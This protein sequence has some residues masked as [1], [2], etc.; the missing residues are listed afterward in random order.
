MKKSLLLL[1]CLV[2][3]GCANSDFPFCCEQTGDK[4]VPYTTTYAF[5]KKVEFTDIGGTLS[6]LRIISQADLANLFN[7]ANVSRVP[8][9]GV[10]SGN[11]LPI[12]GGDVSNMILEATDV[13]GDKIGDLFYNSLG[14]IPDFSSQSGTSANGGFSLLNAPS[15]EVY[16]RVI[17]GGRGKT[18]MLSIP[19]AV[20]LMNISAAAVVPPFIGMLG[21]IQEYW[22]GVAV[23][24][25]LLTPV[26]LKGLSVF[27]SSE[28]YRFPSL[29]SDSHFLIE[30]T[31]AGYLPTYQEVVTDLSARPDGAVD[32]T[33]PLQTLSQASLQ[34]IL[35]QTLF[36]WDPAN[37]QGGVLI[38][39][40]RDADE[41]DRPYS[42]LVLTDDQG[43][44]LNVD[45][46]TSPP[47]SRIYLKGSY[48]DPANRKIPTYFWYDQTGTQVSYIDSSSK[49]Q[50]YDC[51]QTL[52]KSCPPGSIGTPDGSFIVFNLPP[53]KVNLSATA[54]EESAQGLLYFTGEE[55]VEIFPQSA[56][57]KNVLMNQT[58]LGKNTFFQ[59]L[60]GNVMDS[61][62]KTPIGFAAIFAL[63][64]SFSLT[65]DLY[66]FFNTPLNSNILDRVSYTFK[67]S[68]PSYLDTYQ[69]IK[70]DAAFKS[71]TIYSDA[72]L[73]Q[74]LNAAGLST[75]YDSSKG[76][77]AGM[78]VDNGTG[79]GTDGIIL[80]ATDRFGNIVG[81]A[82][83][84][85]SSGLPT[86]NKA[87][88]KNGRYII[89]NL[90]EGPIQVR[91]VSP[92][93]SGNRWVHIYSRGVFLS[94]IHVNNGLPP[95]VQISGVTRDMDGIPAGGAA[96][97]VLGEK[98]RFQSAGDGSFSQSFSTL[99]QYRVKAR[100]P[101]LSLD[102]YSLFDTL[103]SDIG[104][105]T[106]WALTQA[107]ITSQVSNGPSPFTVDF[108]K[109]ILSGTVSSIGFSTP[110]PLSQFPFSPVTGISPQRIAAG[111]FDEDNEV[112]I[113]FVNGVDNKLT[114]LLG[115]G[116]GSFRESSGSPY[117][118]PQGTSLL[119]GQTCLTGANPV[120]VRS[121]DINGDGVLDLMVTNEGTDSM[122]VF[123]G[124]K[125]GNF[126]VASAPL[127]LP[128]G[129]AP[130]AVSVA[131]FNSDGKM[132]L[133]VLCSAASAYYFIPGNGDGTFSGSKYPYNTL[134]NLPV[135]ILSRDFNGDGNLD[136]AVVNSGSNRVSIFLGYGTG[137][138]VPAPNSPYP[139]GLFPVGIAAGDINGDG[140]VD[141]VIPNQGSGT[142]TVLLGKGGGLFSPAT[143][144]PLLLSGFPEFVALNDVN[145][146]GRA[147]LVVTTTTTMTDPGRI[148]T[149]SGLGDGTFSIETGYPVGESPSNLLIADFNDDIYSDLIVYQKGGGGLAFLPGKEVILPSVALEALDLD[150]NLV[151]DVRYLDASGNILSG[152]TQTDVS[153]RFIVYNV[154][155]GMTNIH[156]VSGASG[157][158]FLPSYQGS[159][160]FGNISAIAPRSPSVQ[161]S[162][163]TVDSLGDAVGGGTIV[164][165]VEGVQIS[166]LG[167]GTQTLSD[168]A[169]AVFNL[170]I[171]ANNNMF[172]K[173]QK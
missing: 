40:A 52:T 110:A 3:T 151:G 89:F 66:G 161:F 172:L 133:V 11:L 67:V 144:S 16:I 131:D 157:N 72:M 173:L 77:L 15:G 102:T 78:I 116:D 69:D 30:L 120:S 14:G 2:I 92:D 17:Q 86:L 99:S 43:G 169:S 28:S 167:T 100:A 42:N 149:L 129:C 74:Y 138:F 132:D 94:D 123:L 59:S 96:L 137:L 8:G 127:A 48:L 33:V 87:S 50:T 84:F 75:Q 126:V 19:G 113:A 32:V 76:I 103:M 154:P 53:G 168:S 21:Q 93:D 109:G 38:G 130:V 34:D 22:T 125:K 119:S 37:T 24:N 47:R 139:V 62:G 57:I 5:A 160:T 106:L 114:V 18:S 54:K 44:V 81:D 140:L 121:V 25:A 115:G 51:T 58:T 73:G 56:S 45:T 143:G 117:C 9:T 27:S 29:G 162:G 88:A 80:Q 145:S 26:G 166:V 112:D 20:S 153:G 104:S 35:S 6:V 79:R 85:D 146:D 49:T 141:L 13:N 101:G 60:S 134:G 165:N 164:R 65:A 152:G 148:L 83:Y 158:R 156:A 118:L 46:S 122:T 95:V 64:N 61:D 70:I 163:T 111:L 150:G 82:R 97:S 107:A 71:L 23:Q 135:A 7:A 90:P 36:N 12:F 155:A 170:N 159:A 98:V 68:K 171:D 39:S 4:N 128:S 105:M 10:V 136:L 55:S 91:V 31:A 142:V 108:S 124:T 1:F 63:G 147:D 41:T